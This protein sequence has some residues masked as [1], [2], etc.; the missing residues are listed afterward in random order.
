LDQDE[1]IA[2]LEAASLDAASNGI[3]A[4]LVLNGGASIAILAFLA[5]ALGKDGVSSEYAQLV[6]EMVRSLAFFALGAGA[7]VLT[8]FFAYYANQQYVTSLL[9]GGEVS[10][11]RGVVINIIGA[12]MALASLIL[13][14]IGVYKIWTAGGI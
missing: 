6:R 11:R 8:T 13:Y 9:S 5:Q 2:R 3:K 7:A 1:R 14:G 4:L 12:M 10:W